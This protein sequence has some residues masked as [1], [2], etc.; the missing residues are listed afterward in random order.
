MATPLQELLVI[1][2]EVRGRAV[3]MLVADPDVQDEF[4]YGS[5]DSM[6]ADVCV[7]LADNPDYSKAARAAVMDLTVVLIC[8]R[9]GLHCKN[10]FQTRIKQVFGRQLEDNNFKSRVH[11]SFDRCILPR[12]IE[13]WRS[14]A[15]K[16][17]LLTARARSVPRHMP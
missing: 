9:V 15:S 10:A 5:C 1:F 4:R 12:G 13:T 11:L 14:K 16:R 8:M 3:R 17:G 6:V 7:R 2:A